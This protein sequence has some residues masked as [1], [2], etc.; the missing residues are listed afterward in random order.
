MRWVKKADEK[1]AS[2]QRRNGALGPSCQDDATS[3][4]AQSGENIRDKKTNIGFFKTKTNR[5]VRPI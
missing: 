5:Q 1:A 2:K 3:S 4:T